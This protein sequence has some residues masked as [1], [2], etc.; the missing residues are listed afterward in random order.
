MAK[1]D[2]KTIERNVHDGGVPML[3]ATNPRDERVGPE[4]ALG[5]G[6]TRGDYRGRIGP[7]DYHPHTVV[8]I[9]HTDDEGNVEIETVLV[10]QKALADDVGDEPGLKGGV[11]THTDADAAKAAGVARS[12]AR[13]GPASSAAPAEEPAEQRRNQES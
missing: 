4:D 12:V 13:L 3:P 11:D 10:D 8:A 2:Q 5:A 6:A 1:K 9:E 7:S